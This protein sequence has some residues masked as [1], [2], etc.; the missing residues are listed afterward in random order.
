MTQFK[1]RDILKGIGGLAGLSL[2]GAG[3]LRTALAQGMASDEAWKQASGTTIQ[4]ISENTPPTTAIA[5][6][7]ASFQ[8]LTG[9]TV[10]I[11]EMQLGALVQKVA[12]DFGAGRSSFDVI[13]ADPYQ[14]LAPYHRGLVDLNR[15]INDD[16]Q[17]VVPKGIE[18]FI[19]TQL[20]AAGR[21]E[22]RESLYTLPYDC[23]TMI[24]IYRRDL[25]EK[26]RDQMRQDLG[27][28]PMPSDSTTWEQYY[29]IAEWFSNGNASEVKYGTG[30]QAQQYDSLMCDFSN[31][32]F[33]YGGDYFANGQQVGLL[34]T[35][36]P[37]ACQLTSDAAL[38][39]AR[40]YQNLLK[41][42]HPGSTSWDWTGVA[43][44][45]QNGEFAMMPEWHE[46]A[47]SLESSDLQGKIGYAPLPKGPARSSNLWGG[48]GIG[49][50]A[51]ASAEKQKAAWLFLVWATSP[52]TQLMGLKSTVGGGTPTRQSVYDMPE[53]KAASTPPTDMPN[54]LTADTMLTAWQDDYI[55]LRPKIAQWNEVD[56]VIFTELSK[57]LAGQ[58][59]PEETMQSAKQRIDRIVGA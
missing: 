48:T 1:R 43:N 9:I 53:V 20:A 21:F 4:F 47:G 7:L 18:D 10:N 58:M 23:P 26:Y 11:T 35:D 57:M 45:F 32:L 3:S 19:P 16:Q 31:V 17:P 44:A 22:D 38:E 39:A 27:F 59:S 13:Y 54:M 25:F 30:H 2:M 5:A 36:A 33:A 42:A 37:G 12:L 40:F 55:G 6:N 50:N 14:V 15:F 51:N 24:W 34:G 49:I 28:D 46:F 52:Q 8:E 29:Q 41:V 56:T